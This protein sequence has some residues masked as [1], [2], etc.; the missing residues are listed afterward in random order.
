[1]SSI[2]NYGSFENE[3]PNRIRP[4]SS[5]AVDTNSVSKLIQ[6]PF[7]ALPFT[8]RPTTGVE[9]NKHYSHKSIY[10][11]L[12]ANYAVKKKVV[13]F[14]S[15][16]TVNFVKRPFSTYSIIKKSG[17]SQLEIDDDDGY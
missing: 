17:E 1:M 4:S 7:T 14:R 8:K 6:R 2:D 12:S 3:N 10:S 5:Q 13:Q 15:K 16:S 11:N 9:F